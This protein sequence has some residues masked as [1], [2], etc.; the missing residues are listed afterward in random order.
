VATVMGY[1]FSSCLVISRDVVENR[2]RV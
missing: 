1:S 2:A